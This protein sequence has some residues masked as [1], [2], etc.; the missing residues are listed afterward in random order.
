MQVLVN[1]HTYFPLAIY[2]AIFEYV[3]PEWLAGCHQYIYPQV[4]LVP[5]EQEGLQEIQRIVSSRGMGM[6]I[7]QTRG[8]YFGELTHHNASGMVV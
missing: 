6:N 4:T 7:T 2:Q 3:Y 1:T 8:E 5:I